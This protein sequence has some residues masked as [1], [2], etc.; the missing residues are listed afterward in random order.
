MLSP[1]ENTNKSGGVPQLPNR[2]KRFPAPAC[3]AEWKNPVPA[4]AG[5]RG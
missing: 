4:E 3:G 1:L 2:E 5:G